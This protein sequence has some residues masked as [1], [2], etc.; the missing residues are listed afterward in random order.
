M[1]DVVTIQCSETGESHLQQLVGGLL[2]WESV[3]EAFQAE[4]VEL[5]ASGTPPLHRTGDRTGLT[6]QSFQA[7][8]VI[9]V[10]VTKKG[11]HDS[12]AVGSTTSSPVDDAISSACASVQLLGQAAAG[13]C[14]STS[15]PNGFCVGLGYNLKLWLQ[16]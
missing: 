12:S 15:S 2:D 9:K 6:R 7:N 11:E 10:K 5:E 8:D 16:L 1:A 4:V 3:E 13:T 14:S